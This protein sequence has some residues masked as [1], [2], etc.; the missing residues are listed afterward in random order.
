MPQRQIAAEVGTS[1]T[2]VRRDL[3]QDVPENGTKGSTP[4]TKT[5]QVNELSKSTST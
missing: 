4:A 3:E 2:Q 1:H 5:R